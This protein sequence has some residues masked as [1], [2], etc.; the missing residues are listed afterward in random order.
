MSWSRDGHLSPF[1][2]PRRSNSSQSSVILAEVFGDLF[3]TLE[4]DARIVPETGHGRF[5]QHPRTVFTSQFN[6]A[7]TSQQ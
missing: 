6:P 7:F 5:L 3:E 2:T 4:A 1:G